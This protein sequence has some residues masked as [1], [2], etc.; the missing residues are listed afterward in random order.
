MCRTREK[1]FTKEPYPAVRLGSVCMQAA[2]LLHLHMH[3]DRYLLQV[4]SAPWWRSRACTARRRWWRSKPL[5]L[6]LDVLLALRS[7]SSPVRPTSLAPVF[8][9]SCVDISAVVLHQILMLPCS[10][11][12]EACMHLQLAQLG[13]NRVT[14]L[15]TSFS[16][17]PVSVFRQYI[18]KAS[19][20]SIAG[21][22]RIKLKDDY[23]NDELHISQVTCT[24]LA[25]PG[26]P[27]IDSARNVRLPTSNLL[28]PLILALTNQDVLQGVKVSPPLIFLSGQVGMDHATGEL[29]PGGMKE[30]CEQAF[31]NIKRVLEAGAVEYMLGAGAYWGRVQSLAAADAGGT[32]MASVIEVSIFVADKT[33]PWDAS[34][35]CGVLL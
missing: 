5:P 19:R 15:L 16:P 8:H 13:P 35:E 4:R 27:C 10:R 29:V 23:Y 20:R 7:L 34:L 32:S 2:A 12:P 6:Q 21:M 26:Q 28:A 1:Y 3:G 14:H 33:V 11:E 22:E 18:A 24:P 25:V 30:Q 9:T 17:K 31:A